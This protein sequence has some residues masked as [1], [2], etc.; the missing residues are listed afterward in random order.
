[1]GNRA[2]DIFNSFKLA[3]NDAAKFRTVLDKYDNYFIVKKN[4]IFQKDQFDLRKKQLGKT[5]LSFI[6]TIT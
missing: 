2:D 4:F 6:T 5:A 3:E 1:M